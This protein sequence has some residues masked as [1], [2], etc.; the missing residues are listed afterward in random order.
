LDVY[1]PDGYWEYSV[2]RPDVERW[3]RLYPKLAAPEPTSSKE[4]TL[5]PAPSEELSNNPRQN[6]GPKSDLLSNRPRPVETGISNAIESL[7]SRGIPRHVRAGDRDA[8]IKQ[9]LV[10]KKYDLPNSDG[11][12]RKAVQRALKG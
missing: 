6:P 4:P 8:K 2:R 11:A 5:A 3:E 7:W 9:Y 1:F 10:D 12:L